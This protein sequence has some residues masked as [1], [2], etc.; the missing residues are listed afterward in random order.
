MAKIRENVVIDISNHNTLRSYTPF[1]FLYNSLIGETVT[2]YILQ[3]G[4][5]F[6]GSSLLKIFAGCRHLF[7]LDGIFR[8]AAS[9]TL[10][11]CSETPLNNQ[12][13]FLLPNYFASSLFLICFRQSQRL[14]IFGHKRNFATNNS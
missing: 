8:K 11:F 9:T 13:P 1:V 5:L 14:D 12:T 7:T 6:K 10:L 2:L 3:S 4:V